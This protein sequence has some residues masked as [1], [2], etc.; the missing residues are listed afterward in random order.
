[1]SSTETDRR[2]RPLLLLW[3]R[4]LGLLEQD[5]A[6]RRGTRVIVEVQGRSGSYQKEIGKLCTAELR[7]LDPVVQ[8]HVMEQLL[9][10]YLAEQGYVDLIERGHASTKKIQD[11]T[12]A[13]LPSLDTRI[14]L[15]GSLVHETNIPFF[16]DKLEKPG[17]I[18]SKPS[19][20][21]SYFLSG[22]KVSGTGGKVPSLP[23]AVG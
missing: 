7:S 20:R 9:D 12:P 13:D 19:E 23:V 15:L 18:F 2:K 17:A 1:M 6:E 11:L 3:N 16:Q 14:R 10:R 4:I 21:F 5:L 8:E 22:A